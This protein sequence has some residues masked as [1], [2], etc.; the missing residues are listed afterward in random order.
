MS[1]I[2]EYI[3]CLEKCNNADCELKCSCARFNSTAERNLKTGNP[4]SLY[5]KIIEQN[6]NDAVNQLKS[7]FGF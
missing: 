2:S 4:C 7:F 3:K 6:E 5:F 1:A